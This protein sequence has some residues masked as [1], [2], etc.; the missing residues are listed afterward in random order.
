M[1]IEKK[2]DRQRQSSKFMVDETLKA[3]PIDGVKPTD[4]IIGKEK[5]LKA[6]D[7]GFVQLGD[8][9]IRINTIKRIHGEGNRPELN[10][11]DDTVVVVTDD[12]TIKIKSLK[13][14]DFMTEMNEVRVQLLKDIEEA[15]KVPTELLMPVVKAEVPPMPKA[16]PLEEAYEHEVG[17]HPV[18]TREPKEKTGKVIP[19]GNAVMNRTS[20]VY[21]DNKDLLSG[22][23]ELPLSPGETVVEREQLLVMGKGGRCLGQS[24]KDGLITGEGVSGHISCTGKYRLVF[25]EYA[26]P[27]AVVTY[28]VKQGDVP[29]VG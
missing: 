28:K 25:K 7:I 11:A 29:P 22:S 23:G 15:M 24:T 12:D 1:A 19:L 10:A 9:L 13:W 21:I 20:T 5:L 6:L 2:E 14:P 16:P 17:T 3:V 27:D 8:N 4:I 18:P 26:Y